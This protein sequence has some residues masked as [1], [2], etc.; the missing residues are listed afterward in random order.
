MMAWVSCY[1]FP[2]LQLDAHLPLCISLIEG[3]LLA[4]A[5]RRHAHLRGGPIKT[6]LVA[7]GLRQP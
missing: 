3:E 4:G 5:C 7:G 1:F 2:V 6:P